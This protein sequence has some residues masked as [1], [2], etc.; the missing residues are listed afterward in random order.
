MR[1]KVRNFMEQYHMVEKGDCVLAA[2]SGGADSLCL[3]MLLLELHRE[4]GIRLCA[5]HVEHGIRGEESLK[6]AEFV[7]KFCL[8]NQ[9]PCKIC[10]CDAVRYAK[11][12]KISLEEGARELRYQYFRQTA[13]AFKADKIAVA[14]N[15]N[16]C[17][18]TMLFHLARGTEL[19]GLCGIWPVRDQIIRP[20]L[21]VERREIESYL[22]EHDQLYCKDQTNEE[23]LYTRNKIRHQILPVLSEI[24]DQAV[25][26]MNQT[27]VSAYEAWELIE[28]LTDHAVKEYMFQKD[29]GYFLSDKLLNEKPVILRAVL[30]R[31]LT[32]AAGKSRD[33][34]RIH[35][36]QIQDL[37][38][39]QTGRVITL[40]EG[41]QARRT[42]QGIL[43]IRKEN[44]GLD[45]EQEWLLPEK[46]SVFISS[47]EYEVQTRVFDKISQNEEI[48]KNR[49]T[50][51]MD[52]D[53]IKGTMRMRTPQEQDF[54]VIDAQGNRKKL[55]RYF[56]DEKVPGYRRGQML[57]LADDTHIL[58]VIGYRISEDVKVTEHTRRILEIRVNGGTAHE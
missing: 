52:Y 32:Q 42:Y 50:K 11:E 13:E 16:D 47:Y 56:A 28:N 19:R 29:G 55:N 35:V 2:V 5:V 53:K 22:A 15:Q 4:L 54:L 31:I 37:F 24:N 51:W 3:L 10:R 25:A 38:H 41:V 17:A 30:H 23:L 18:E 33:I 26:H 8:H 40:P 39:L 6:D 12:Q 44:Q 7:E 43:L 58:W 20:L 36:R 46:G 1:K 48:P 34:S 9:I 57:L 49:Y 45:I 21:C 27:A 14:H